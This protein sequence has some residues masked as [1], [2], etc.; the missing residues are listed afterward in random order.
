MTV[1]FWNNLFSARRACA[2]A[3]L[4]M[5]LMAAVLAP[6]AAQAQQR[7]VRNYLEG[8]AYPHLMRYVGTDNVDAV[9]N[10]P[11]IAEKLKDLTGE[12]YDI[13][14]NFD[15]AEAISLLGDFSVPRLVLGGYAVIE[16]RLHRKRIFI[17]IDGAAPEA[18]ISFNPDEPYAKQK[19]ILFSYSWDY[20]D[21]SLEAL[22]EPL[23][24]NQFLYQAQRQPRMVERRHPL[25]PSCNPSCP[26]E[27]EPVSR[28]NK[29]QAPNNKPHKKR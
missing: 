26:P 9:L 21:I 3:C 8:N 5:A 19:H 13:L 18:A 20:A 23:K 15:G 28:L 1:R 4:L 12:Y 29:S 11:A 6:D 7:T 2:A 10:D 24:Y 27:R 14:R 17:P 16:G 25:R 22:F